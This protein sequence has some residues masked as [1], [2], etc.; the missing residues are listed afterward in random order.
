M[1]INPFTSTSLEAARLFIQANP[2]KTV[3]LTSGSWDLFHDFHLR[4]LLR[5]RR[6]C[7][8]LIVGV[9]SDEE[10]RRAKGDGRPFQSEF[11]RQMLL[12]SNKHVTFAYI[13]DGVQDLQRVAEALLT[14]RGGKI[15]KNQIF[16]G[17]EDKIRSVLGTASALTEIV[18]IP[19]IEE[20]NSTSALASA[21]RLS[22]ESEM[23]RPDPIKELAATG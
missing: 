7:D 23:P 17:K 9:D 15:F 18:F 13:Q 5:C 2:N 1:I 12:D 8:I 21:I 22:P 11:Q 20:M 16:R 19:D 14:V 4:F 10:I 3:G 6:H